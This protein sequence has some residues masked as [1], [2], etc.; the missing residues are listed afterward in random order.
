MDKCKLVDMADVKANGNVEVQEDSHF[1]GLADWLDYGTIFLE[2]K[3][4]FM[5]PPLKTL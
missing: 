2:W 3:I 5:I 4:D 1:V